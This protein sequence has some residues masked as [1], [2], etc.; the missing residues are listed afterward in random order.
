MAIND[1]SESTVTFRGTSVVNKVI[2]KQLLRAD[3][4]GGICGHKMDRQA[5]MHIQTHLQTSRLHLR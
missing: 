4:K 3:V 2:S 1:T 5:N